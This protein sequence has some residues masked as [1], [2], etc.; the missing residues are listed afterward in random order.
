MLFTGISHDLVLSHT[1][2]LLYPDIRIYW[3][4]QAVLHSDSAPHT[5]HLHSPAISY[6]IFHKYER[7]DTLA[8]L[9]PAMSSSHAFEFVSLLS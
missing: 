6:A 8:F 9:I 1:I 3:I 7:N 2:N 5:L 4:P